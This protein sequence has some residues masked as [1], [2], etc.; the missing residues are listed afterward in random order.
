MIILKFGGTS[1]REKSNFAKTIDIIVRQRKKERVG[2]VVSALSGVTD[3][4]L[5][6]VWLASQGRLS[7]ARDILRQIYKIHNGL[8]QN[9]VKPASRE[10]I[11]RF[12]KSE[13]KN[14]ETYLKG[15]SLTGESSQQTRDYIAG[16]GEILSSALVTSA[17][18]SRGIKAA[19]VDTR[20]HIVTDD[21]FGEAHI[22]WEETTKRLKKTL[23]KQLKGSLPVIT[24]FIGATKEAIPTTIGR[25]GSDY[26]AAIVAS[27][28]DA[29]RLEIW[30]DVDG[31]M[32]A[33]PRRVSE[34]FT[35]ER[36]SYSEMMEL[37]YFGAEVI[38]PKLFGPVVDKKIPILIKNTLSPDHPGTLISSKTGDKEQMVK[39]ITSIEDVALITIV[40]RGLLGVPGMAQRFFAA[41]RRADINVIMISQSSSEQN[42][43]C[44]VSADGAKAGVRVVEEEFEWELRKKH[45]QAVNCMTDVAIIA[46]VGEGMKGRPGVAG[47]LFSVLGRNNVNVIAIA[48]GSSEINISFIVSRSDETRA[49]NLIHGAFKLSTHHVNLF[50]IGKGTI[51]GKLIELIT[52]H[53][54]SLLKETDISL[55]VVGIADSG[56]YLFEPSG[57]SLKQ[58]RKNLSHAGKKTD[59]KKITGELWKSGLENLIFVDATASEDI[60]KCYPQ[61]LS[62]GI[63][64]VTPNKKANTLS[65][66]FYKELMGLKQKRA[67]HYYY[68]TSVGAGLPVISTLRDL[69]DSGDEIV[70][71]GGVFSG[72][73]SYIFYNLNRGMKF[74]RAVAEAKRLGLTE[75]DPR[76]DLSGEDVARKILIL[77]REIGI[78]KELKDIKVEGLVPKRLKNIP[79]NRFMKE[80][81]KEDSK[82]ASIINDAKKKNSRLQYVGEIKNRRIS[83]GLR[84]FPEGSPY[85][86]INAKDNMV[87]FK[88]RRYFDNQL[89]VQG[90]GAG[91][92]VTAAGV[93]ADIIKV[94]QFLRR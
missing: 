83:V 45:V 14:L 68:E 91:P 43:C 40:G 58:W 57:L 26:T 6:S 87:V 77:A 19:S 70:E 46:L 78:L 39:G 81:G 21:H 34:V 66:K 49:L 9:F 71:I 74:S 23:L 28:I 48:Q 53:K 33:D 92:E 22:E 52:K 50:V 13:I 7:E 12:I 42:I 62:Q 24:G 88:T 67:G 63:S 82:F 31:V 30:T 25:S 8:I 27:V 1:L 75:P 55:K 18:S 29:K 2:V 69:L 76:V 54:D 59:I 10:D 89:V 5:K 80:I 72:T 85:G 16:H 65:A 32:S 56:H 44:A 86:A 3:S 36:L 15:L 84:A 93:F 35:I 38:H 73:L 4:L 20:A 11:K 51:G 94:A 47:R 90:P 41:L 17:L 64:I 37:A 61:V 60:A 79:L